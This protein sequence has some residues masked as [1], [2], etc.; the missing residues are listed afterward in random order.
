MNRDIEN[1]TQ[2]YLEKKMISADRGDSTSALS[3]RLKA[4]LDN[5]LDELS[6]TLDQSKT[7]LVSWF[8]EAG[9][10]ELN[11]LLC[12]T[13]QY[14]AVTENDDR[15]HKI[16][17]LNTNFNNDEETHYNMIRNQEAAAFHK[18]WKESILRLSKG[19]IVYLYQSGVG[20][21]ARG[22]VSGELEKGVRDNIENA[23]YSKKLSNFEMGFKAISAKQFREI[24]GGG[25]NFR[26]VLVELNN[27]QF[28]AIDEEIN[29]RLK[30]S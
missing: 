14:D 23:K 3:I 27:D 6:L 1:I 18:G 25:T 22:I 15:P 12:K 21:V 7:T 29:K 20:I 26:M 4:S 13:N 24:T 17:M 9:I 11:Y 5:Q 19:D 8:I 30:G 28:K 16:F 10:E 2:A